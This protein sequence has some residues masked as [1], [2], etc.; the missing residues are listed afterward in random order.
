LHFVPNKKLE[1]LDFMKLS[2][3]DD[4]IEKKSVADIL[5]ND[6]LIDKDMVVIVE[7]NKTQDEELGC[8]N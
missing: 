6:A 4:I 8:K 3:S 2:S 1:N 7:E 5:A